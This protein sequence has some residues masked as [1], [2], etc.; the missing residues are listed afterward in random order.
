MLFADS[1][2]IKINKKTNIKIKKKIGSAV[3]KR[4]IY[5][6]KLKY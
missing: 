4:Q 2:L 1:N 6:T 3:D 5:E